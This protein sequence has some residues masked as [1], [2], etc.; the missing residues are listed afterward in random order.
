MAA[1]EDNT[2]WT[3]AQMEAELPPGSRYELHEGTLLDRSPSANAYHQEIVGNL[4][5]LLRQHLK[6]S[7][8][9][10]VFVA[11]LDVVL[12]PD[13]VVQPD[14]LVLLGNPNRKMQGVVQEVP[15]L[16]VEIL[17]PSNSQRDKVEKRAL[18]AQYGIKE[19]WLADP[20]TETFE[21]LQL[22]D[23]GYV[24][25]D[26]STKSGK[27]SSALLQGLVVDVAEVFGV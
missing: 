22:S 21:I 23:E 4:Y 7:G 6:S 18:Y 16:V 17:S 1:L 11:P 14:L 27:V 2:R 5:V 19:Y 15:G 9:V 12:A 3:F 25:F 20:D 10:K 13:E 8:Q 24:L 26:T